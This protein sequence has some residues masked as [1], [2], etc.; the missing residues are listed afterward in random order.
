MKKHIIY[1]LKGMIVGLGKIIPGVSGALLAISLN[2]YDKGIDAITNFFAKKKENALFLFSAGSGILL[3]IVLFSNVLSFLLTNFYFLTMMLFLGLILGGIIPFIKKNH[4]KRLSFI[5]FL[6]FFLIIFLE[7]I[8]IENN[9]TNTS[10][11]PYLIS[12]IIDAFATVT[13]GVSGTSLLLM[14]GTYQNIIAAIGTFSFPILIPYGIGMFLGI[15][16]FSILINYLYKKHP[17]VINNIICGLSSATSIILFTTTILK[18]QNILELF[19]GLFLLVVGIYLGN[20]LK[21]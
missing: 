16:L 18:F 12:G 1:F 21:E 6:S 19:L 13:P 11:I 14:Y 2:I 15:I 10:F 8:S 9:L 3:S 7:A 17:F 5:T 20:L 4:Q